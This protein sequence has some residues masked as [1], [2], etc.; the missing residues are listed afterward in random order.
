MEFGRHYLDFEVLWPLDANVILAHTCVSVCFSPLFCHQ[1]H[2]DNNSGQF[3]QF[4]VTFYHIFSDAFLFVRHIYQVRRFDKPPWYCSQGLR[5]SV[6]TCIQLNIIFPVACLWI[7]SSLCLWMSWPH[8]GQTIHRHKAAH[9]DSFVKVSVSTVN[10][11]VP[12]CVCEFDLHCA[13]GCSGQ[14]RSP[15]FLSRF[16]YPQYFDIHFS[17]C[18]LYANL[19][20]TV[21]V[22]VL[23]PE[24]PDHPQIRC[25][26]P[27]WILFVK[28][29][30]STYALK[31]I[32]VTIS[33]MWN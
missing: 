24:V 13:C 22:D 1:S 25:W 10:I 5:V 18:F 7:W 9:R 15:V 20:F 3:P 6:S 31:N 32:V 16:Q 12:V 29:S 26:S 33:Y 2:G 19:I 4:A 14:S 23:S 30:I 21:P 27:K 17:S 28:I 8:E 11:A